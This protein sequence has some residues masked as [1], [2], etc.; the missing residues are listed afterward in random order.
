MVN[1]LYIDQHHTINISNIW[2]ML[3]DWY[4]KYWEISDYSYS[5][6]YVMLGHQDSKYWTISY[7]HISNIEFIFL[8]IIFFYE[9]IFIYYVYP[10]ARYFLIIEHFCSPGLLNDSFVQ[11]SRSTHYWTLL[12]VYFD[13]LH[14][15]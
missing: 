15:C 14:I 11:A 9:L 12:M 10:Q 7:H 13:V 5:K 6:F 4:Y 1:I 3:H 8:W 2:L